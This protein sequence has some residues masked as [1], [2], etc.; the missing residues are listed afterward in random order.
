MGTCVYHVAHRG[1]G[2]WFK[3][4]M[5]NAEM[6]NFTQALYEARELALD[7]MQE[8]AMTVDSDGI[9]GVIIE[10]RTYGW[11]SHVIDLFAIA[12]AIREVPETASAE[13]IPSPTFTISLN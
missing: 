3:Q 12:R 5:R 8:E 13:P 11:D 2:Q 1:I 9:V 7:R 10:E 4:V 6:T